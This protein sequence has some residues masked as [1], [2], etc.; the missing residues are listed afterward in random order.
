MKF[1]DL[2]QRD[3]EL[4][5]AQYRSNSPR[6]VVQ[7]E[8]SELFGVSR[9][10]IRKW[11]NRLELGVLKENVTNPSRILIY[12]IETP[13]LMAELWWS[14]KQYVNGNDIMDEPRII[15]IS[16]KW[17][18]E[19]KVHAAHWDLATQDDSEMMKLFLEAYNEAD[20][21]VGINNDRFDNRWINA[22]AMKHGLDVNTFVRSIDIQKQAKRLLRLP[23]YSLKYMCEYFD[24][25][26]QK[27]SHE[28]LVMWR[29]IQYGTMEEREEYMKKMIDY[30]VGDI[31][32]TEGLFLRLM[33]MLNLHTHLGVMYGNEAYSCPLCG[34][35]EDIELVKTTTT[36][37]GTIQ[38][39]MRCNVDGAKF[40][41]GNRQ[42][43]NW[44]NGK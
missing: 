36:R 27:L 33:P 25:P 32:A 35:T 29:K 5:T 42:Y 28:G 39:V 3:I 4:I 26:Q 7:K 9:R 37:A 38:H 12:D 15:S 6:R 18:G 19:E 21:V 17:Y 2:G 34:E 43:L 13:R 8:L 16:W 41:I 31:L 22:R 30:N 20:V 10:T 44:L 11:A 14:G 1:K 24:I 23:S 40:K